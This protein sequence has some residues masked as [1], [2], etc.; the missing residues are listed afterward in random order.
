[1]FLPSFDLRPDLMR[2]RLRARPNRGEFFALAL[3]VGV[4][5]A[6]L[7]LA[8]SGMV[9][10]DYQGHINVADGDY[11]LFFFAEWAVPFYRFLALLPFEVG[12]GL[13]GI[14]EIL[15]VWFACRVFNGNSVIAVTGYQMLY[16]LYY[17]QIVGVVLGGLALMWWGIVQKRYWLAGVG[18]AVA[19]VKF[20]M[21]TPLA[22]CLWL[23]A[24]LSWHNRFKIALIPAGVALISLLA[25]PLWPWLLLQ[26]IIVLPP[27]SQGSI[28]LWRWIGP[29]ALV[30]WVPPIAV[31]LLPGKRLAAVA[32]ASALA[33][34]YF[35]Q[36]DLLMLFVLPIG[37]LGLLGNLG[38]LMVAYHWKA[39][40]VLVVVP[41][42]IYGWV[43]ASHF[44]EAR[45]AASAAE[46]SA[47]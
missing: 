8:R 40:Q 9:G 2:E 7:Q 29:A 19:L 4:Q 31:R 3:A 12:Y 27:D 14:L 6:F 38:Y 44:L 22:I 43:F 1:M 18:L 17:G 47:A 39:L 28:S 33:L 20:Q 35:Q 34:P 11:S 21:G 13:L 26:R 24:D 10:I 15:G 25:A 37:W 23:T 42:V 16:C 45:R 46:S 32:A 36:T 5:L 41:L 30:L